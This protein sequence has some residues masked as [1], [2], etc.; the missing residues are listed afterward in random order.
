[1]EDKSNSKKNQ[2]TGRLM[3]CWEEKKLRGL[4]L[5]ESLSKLV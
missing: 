1:M 5:K 4:A 2:G 3:A